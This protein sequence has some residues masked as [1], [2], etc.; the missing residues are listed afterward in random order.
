MSWVV[1]FAGDGRVT[2]VHIFPDADTALKASGS[3][4]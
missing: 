3:E 2:R 4:E 1:D